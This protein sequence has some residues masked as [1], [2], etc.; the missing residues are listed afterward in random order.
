MAVVE[1]ILV[2]GLSGAVFGAIL[3]LASQKFHVEQDPRQDEIVQLLPG[4]N[5]GAC[6]FPGCSGLAASIVAGDARVNACPV[7]GSETASRIAAIMGVEPVTETEKKV[8]R[9]LC[10]GTDERCAPRYVYDGLRQCKAQNMVAGGAKS[11][12]YGCL[13]LGSCVDACKFDAIHMGPSGLPT[14]NEA[15]CTSC[16][17]CV[18]ACPR[19]IIQLMPM[20]QQVTV[21]CRSKARGAE[22][23]KTC[24]IGC[25]GCGICAKACPKGAI[26]LQDNLAVINLEECD[27]CGICVEKCPTKCIVMRDNAAVVDEARSAS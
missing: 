4:A 22:V 13:G 20:S 10:Q 2:L 26:T 23:R 6:G 27:A 11:C 16:G 8:A 15:R 18:D 14:V 25:I 19:G 7:S 9:V 1:A 17:M 5:C 3:A 12:V 24:K 21:F